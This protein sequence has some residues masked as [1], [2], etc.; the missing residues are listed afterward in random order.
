[1]T[2]INQDVATPPTYMQGKL[3]INHIYYIHPVIWKGV[4]H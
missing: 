4:I 1:M 2:T 3:F